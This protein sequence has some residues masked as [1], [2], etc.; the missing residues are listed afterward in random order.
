MKKIAKTQTPENR[1]RV[2]IGIM[3]F[4][5]G[6]VLLG[7]RKG[8]YASGEYCFPGGH[9]EYMES[10]KACALREIAEESG[11]KVKNLKFCYLSNMKDYAPRHYVLIGFVAD[12]KSGTPKIL[13]PDKYDSWD[14]YDTDKLPTPTFVGSS[15]ILEGYKKKIF[16][17]DAK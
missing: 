1:P 11:I 8:S 9:L 16:Y 6:K 17:R 4:K 2:G 3:I 5:K 7:K 15:E 12:W 14:W 10:F 13:E